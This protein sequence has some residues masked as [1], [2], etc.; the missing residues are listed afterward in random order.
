M[1]TLQQ[2]FPRSSKSFLQANK[3]ALEGIAPQ[4][5]AADAVQGNVERLAPIPRRG[6]MNKTEAAFALILEAQ[7]RKG[8]IL[9]Y[10]FEGITLRFAGVR[11]TP[12]F[13]V[14]PP[15]IAV[16]GQIKFIEVK[17]PFVKGKFGSGLLRK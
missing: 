10:D 12:D 2:L 4:I 13:V 6:H 15:A 1:K 16:S 17:G 14:F 8:D 5:Q 7:K 9:R 11:Y 3:T